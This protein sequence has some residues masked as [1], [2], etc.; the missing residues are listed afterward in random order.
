MMLFSGLEQ[1]RC[2]PT[3]QSPG[4]QLTW[5]DAG[6]LCPAVRVIT[7]SL[8]SAMKSNGICSVEQ[9]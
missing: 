5:G 3:S 2:C 6:G 9:I 1:H 4:E 7:L 8:G